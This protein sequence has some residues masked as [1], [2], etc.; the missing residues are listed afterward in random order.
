[1]AEQENIVVEVGGTGL[2]LGWNKTLAPLQLLAKSAS[3]FL[4]IYETQET[5]MH[6]GR[7]QMNPGTLTSRWCMV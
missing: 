6:G 1:M 2:D 7:M 4:W 5:G 3:V